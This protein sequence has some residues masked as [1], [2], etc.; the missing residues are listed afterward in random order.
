MEVKLSK[1]LIYIISGVLLVGGVAWASR[2]VS[3][4]P[5]TPY[6]GTAGADLPTVV[7]Q[8]S[9]GGPKIPFSATENYKEYAPEI[10]AAALSSGKATLIYFYANWCGSCRGQEPINAA[11]F[12][13]T[14]AENLAV[15]GVRVNVD[16]NQPIMRQYGINY[17]HSY[18][19][20]DKNGNPVDR[21][22]GEH[23]EEELM[24]KVQKV[25]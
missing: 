17:Q 16:E 7:G 22:F 4:R 11:F 2:G 25:L 18:V 19:L 12:S 21:F 8:P 6:A 20:L 3:N 5:V 15:T 10:L 13:R 24:T 1:N 23:S 9:L 14:L